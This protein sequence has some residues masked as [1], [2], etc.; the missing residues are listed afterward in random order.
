MSDFRARE[1]EYKHFLYERRNEQR[2][3]RKEEKEAAEAEKQREM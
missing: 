3:K 2:L 1:S